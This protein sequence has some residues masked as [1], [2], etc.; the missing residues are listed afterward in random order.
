VRWVGQLRGGG[1]LNANLVVSSAQRSSS[2]NVRLEG[3][4]TWY[5]LDTDR[6]AEE[7]TLPAQSTCSACRTL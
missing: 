2:K 4:Y 3:N 7:F 1:F 6:N 5:L